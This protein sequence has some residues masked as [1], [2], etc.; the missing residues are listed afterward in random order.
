MVDS[1][2]FLCYNNFLNSEKPYP[3]DEI[4][5]PRNFHRNPPG[6]SPLSHILGLLF[7][8]VR[9][10]QCALPRN[11]VCASYIYPFLRLILSEITMKSKKNIA[12]VDIKE[13]INRFIL[14]SHDARDD[15]R[16]EM[17][18]LLE[19]I[20]MS[21]GNYHGFRYLTAYDMKNSEY[22]NTVGINTD[23]HD[24]ILNTYE[25]RFE[26]TDPTRVSYL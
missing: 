23:D 6:P 24:A 3:S 10:E 20:L 15:P 13:M 22:G 9:G 25:E 12:V 5:R 17:G 21:T 1:I 7:R 11:A 16:S 2:S 19:T 18:N 4:L 26:N 14:D 8:C